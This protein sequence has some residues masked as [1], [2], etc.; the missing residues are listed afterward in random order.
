MSYRVNF[1]LKI[2]KSAFSALNDV[3]ITSRVSLTIASK[4]S[5]YELH[6]DRQHVISE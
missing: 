6:I 2:T 5:V 1:F 4:S 3:N